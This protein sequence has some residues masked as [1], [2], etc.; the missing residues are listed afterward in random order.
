MSDCIRALRVILP[1]EGEFTDDV[2]DPGN[3]TGGAKGKGV[4]RGTKYGISAAAYPN[5]DI[6][7]LSIDDVVPLYYQ[8][9]WTP[10]SA[11][12]LHWPLNLFVFDAAINQGVDASIK[13]LQGVLQLKQDGI[14]G[15]NTKAAMAKA[16]DWN[17][18][19]FMT[20]RALRYTGTRNFDKYG[21]GWLNRLFHLVQ[22]A[23]H[24]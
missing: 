7:N 21:R 19:E 11:D 10:V 14:I 3:W 9:Y 4:L 12:L 2:D 6:K 24:A 23:H 13:M 18:V 1:V 5:L 22:E 20:A 17:A 16:T 15:R 8:D